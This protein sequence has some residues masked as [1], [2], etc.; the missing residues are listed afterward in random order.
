MCQ[1]LA[2]VEYTTHCCSASVHCSSQSVECLSKQTVLSLS[3]SFGS[4]SSASHER[5]SVYRALLV[6]HRQPAVRGLFQAEEHM[7][8]KI[9]YTTIDVLDP[10]T[11]VVSRGQTLFR[12][13]GRVWDM[14]VEQLVAPHCGVRTNHSTVF[15]HMIPEVCEN[16]KFQFE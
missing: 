9:S 7:I 4:S 10:S 14:A 1:H 6:A 12:T 8:S 3:G 15:S 11:D 2:V 13:E 5:V 16:S